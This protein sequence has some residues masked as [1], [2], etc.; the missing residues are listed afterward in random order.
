[1]QIENDHYLLVTIVLL[2]C[3][4]GVDC[5]WIKNYLEV[6]GRPIILRIRILNLRKFGRVNLV[7]IIFLGIEIVRHLKEVNY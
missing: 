7:R 4:L 6:D 3:S 1:M 5:A 2:N